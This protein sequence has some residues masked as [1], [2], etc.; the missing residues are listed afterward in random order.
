MYSD[1]FLYLSIPSMLSMFAF[2]E[3]KFHDSASITWAIITIVI[4]ERFGPLAIS[5]GI[6]MTTIHLARATISWIV[7]KH[8]IEEDINNT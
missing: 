4:L 8:S 6:F 3:N 5:L 7:K 2:M 1:I